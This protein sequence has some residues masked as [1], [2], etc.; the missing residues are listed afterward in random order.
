MRRHKH[1]VD[2]E[3]QR[4][5]RELLTMDPDSPEALSL[6]DKSPEELFILFDEDDSGL[7]SYKE[8][9]RMLPFL[10]VEISDAKALRYFKLCDTNDDDNIDI[11]EFRVALYICNPT[12]G[13]NVGYSPYKYLTPLDAF[14]TFDDQ[15]IGLLDEDEFFFGL[16]YLGIKL[17]DEKQE[18][19]FN[20]YDTDKSGN[21]D[22]QEFREGKSELVW[23]FELRF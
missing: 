5:R 16:D 6:R 21:I 1:S 15:N 8:F 9:R 18:N 22:Y 14:Q 12:T 23:S 2:T 13:N 4:L 7:I 10:S 17:S 3:A 19:L 11:E 20:K